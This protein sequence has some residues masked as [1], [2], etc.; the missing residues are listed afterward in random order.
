MGERSVHLVLFT[1]QFSSLLMI[2]VRN[3]SGGTGSRAGRRS[4]QERLRKPELSLRSDFGKN[5]VSLRVYFVRLIVASS[6]AETSITLPSRSLGFLCVLRGSKDD[7]DLW[8]FCSLSVIK[9][10]Y[11]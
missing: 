8:G 4:F 2:P 3:A 10:D 7:S 11:C 5:S 6:A 1:T 9:P